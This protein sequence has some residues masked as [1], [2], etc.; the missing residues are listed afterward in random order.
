MIHLCESLFFRDDRI[1]RDPIARCADYVDPPYS[2]TLPITLNI[3]SNWSPLH[4]DAIPKGDVTAPNKYVLQV[5][6]N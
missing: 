3:N 6:F 4:T 2:S 1:S 5:K